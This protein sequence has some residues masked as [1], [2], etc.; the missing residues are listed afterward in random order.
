MAV[1]FAC[2]RW[3]VGF[4]SKT[5]GDSASERVSHQY[6]PSLFFGNI[7]SPEIYSHVLHRF[8]HFLGIQT[9]AIESAKC[10]GFGGFVAN[11]IG[12]MHF[13]LPDQS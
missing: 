13:Q 6:P 7:C 1:G 3:L 12:L 10:L 5:V 11:P 4:S 9:I 8:R 2:P